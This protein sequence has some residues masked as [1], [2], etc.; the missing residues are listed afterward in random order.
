M[1]FWKLAVGAAT[2]LLVAY[3]AIRM[4]ALWDS[5]QVPRHAKQ[6]GAANVEREKLNK[7]QRDAR[8]VLVREECGEDERCNRDYWQ[9]INAWDACREGQVNLPLSCA[10]DYEAA[11][12]R[13]K[14]FAGPR[15]GHE[16]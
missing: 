16:H 9:A 15:P 14:A 5:Y 10:T 7:R 4:P 6:E 11:V 8:M 3:A 2:G 13:A 12:A 1:S